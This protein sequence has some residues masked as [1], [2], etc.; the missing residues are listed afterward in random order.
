MYTLYYS[1]GTASLVV[2]WMLIHIGAP[3]ELKLVDLE[4]GAQKDPAYLSLNPDGRVPT[5]VVDGKAVNEC[6]ALTMLLAERH[7]EVGLEPRPGSADRAAY[8][9]WMVFFA[10]SLL[11]S[12]RQW[13]YPNE[14]AGEANAEAAQASARA[15]IE[16]VFERMDRQLSDGRAHLLGERI[17]AADFVGTMLTR[18]SRNMPKP[19]TEWPHLKAYIDR[20]RAMPSLKDV[21]A[22][23]GL[24]EWISG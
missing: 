16:T 5:L 20:M 22:R 10:N 11:P 18:W 4:T 19:A 12:F 9:Q 1:P 3:F 24:T 8:L 7:P 23:E 15:R 13:F 6:V 21:H 17:S 2:H 14:A